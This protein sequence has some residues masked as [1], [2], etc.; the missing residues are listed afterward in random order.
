[1]S[2]AC[3]DKKFIEAPVASTKGHCISCANCPWME[4]NTLKALIEALNNVDEHS[5]H[6]D[7]SIAKAATV[8]LDRMLKFSADLKS[9]KIVLE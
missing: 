6:V 9:G 5:V 7:K 2:L 1:M 4:L 3:P 8:P